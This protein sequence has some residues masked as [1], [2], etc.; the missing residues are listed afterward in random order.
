MHGQKSMQNNVKENISIP[1]SFQHMHCYF[2]LKKYAVQPVVEGVENTMMQV[3]H[4]LNE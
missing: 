1:S 2:L 3:F 4:V